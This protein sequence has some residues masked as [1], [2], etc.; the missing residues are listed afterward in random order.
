MAKK[1]SPARS[2]LGRAK[3]RVSTSLILA[4]TSPQRRAILEQLAVPFEIVV[5][6]FVEAPDGDPREHAAG[7]ARSVDGAGFLGRW[8]MGSVKPVCTRSERA[9]RAEAR[10]MNTHRPTAAR[11]CQESPRPPR[12]C[13]RP[14]TGTPTGKA[15]HPFDDERL[16]PH[17]SRHMPA[18]IGRTGAG[19][20]RVEKP[21]PAACARPPA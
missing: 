14:S 8:G 13:A 16:L 3:A 20:S 21:R 17:P 2:A 6:E 4:S 7:K 18:P 5:P 1:C 15:R 12:R 10:V 19:V 9:A 11:R